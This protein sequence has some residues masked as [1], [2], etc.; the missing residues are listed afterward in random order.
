LQD[1]DATQSTTIAFGM[2]TEAYANFGLIGCALLGL[3]QGAAFKK[4]QV[5]SAHSPLFSLAGLMMI[6]MTA[7]AFNS[8][9]TMA[10]WVSSLFQ[11][12]VVVLGIPLALRAFF[13]P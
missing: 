1:E 3:V 10:A 12:L 9:M 6:L 4:L 5:W 8:E 2:L 7:W 11:A 13:A